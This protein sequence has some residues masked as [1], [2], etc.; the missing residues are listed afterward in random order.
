MLQQKETVVVLMLDRRG[1]VEDT[2]V[3]VV[4][5]V[6]T[7]PE[8]GGD[9]DVLL[10]VGTHSSAGLGDRLESVVNLVD[11]IVVVHITSSNN[12]KVITEVVL[13]AVLLE[14]VNGEVLKVVSITKDRLSHHMV[15]VSVVVRVLNGSAVVFASGPFVLGSDLLF[16]K[17]ELSSVKGSVGDGVSKHVNNL[18]D[19]VLEASDLDVG[20]FTVGLTC[21]ASAHHFDLLSELGF[22]AASSSVREHVGE[23]VGSARSGE[24]VL[25]GAS[26][27]VNTDS[28]SQGVG[29]F[30]AN[31]DSV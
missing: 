10:R 13:G 12:N 27:N 7:N 1:I 23:S 11:E 16:A 17:F 5:L 18:A 3:R 2:N 20:V 26:T 22:G 24:G 8:E 19:V 6:I 31:A 29:L 4:H 25:A 28:G 14:S 15:T 30:S 9:V 21:E